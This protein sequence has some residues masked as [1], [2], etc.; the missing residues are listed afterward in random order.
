MD[1]EV[2]I[3]PQTS[4][5]GTAML[6]AMVSSA[7]SAG[8]RVL[9][10]DQYSGRSNWLMTYG[11]GHP[12]RRLWTDAHLKAGGRLIG[13]DLG[14]WDREVAMRLTIDRDHPQHLIRQMDGSRF[15]ADRIQLRDD[16]DPRGPIILAALGRKTR[17]ILNDADRS[18][19]RS[20]LEALRSIYPNKTILYRA[21][22]QE[23]FPPLKSINGDIEKVLQGASL[24][25]C[26]HSNVAIDACIAG[27]PVVCSDGIASAL[28]GNDLKNV[29][30]PDLA[31]RLQ[32]LRNVAWWQWRP[33]EAAQ[34]WKHIISILN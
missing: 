17:L 9:V 23:S 21:K 15:A 29:T 34:A 8:V 31:T 24:V 12:T 19:E 14:Y 2:L 10:G 18:W 7:A 11:L 33:T 5:R 26:K 20:T 4:S 30:K 1:C 13:W 6:K 16:Y 3:C 22:R 32:F 25:V 27:I 28:Y